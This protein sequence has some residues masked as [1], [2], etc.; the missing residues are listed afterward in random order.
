M[1][2]QLQSDFGTPE[3]PTAQGGE[4]G[5]T[6][7][8]EDLFGNMPARLKF[9]KSDAAESTQIK[10]VLKLETDSWYKK[11]RF[12]IIDLIFILFAMTS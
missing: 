12:W 2:Y 3:S 7:I 8:I 9:L 10:N 5:T 6:I 11:R 1:A 4:K